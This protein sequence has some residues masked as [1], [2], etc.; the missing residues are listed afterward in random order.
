MLVKFDQDKIT[1]KV[2]NELGI[3]LSEKLE[4]N[5]RKFHKLMKWGYV[6]YPKTCVD[7]K[8]PKKCNLQVVLHGCYQ[9]AK[10][11]ADHWVPY[12]QENELVL[13]LP[14]AN[15]CWDYGQDEKNSAERAFPNTN[16]I[17]QTGFQ[18]NFFMKI[19]E[20]VTKP[21]ETEYEYFYQV[22]DD[23]DADINAEFKFGY[24]EFFP[25][26]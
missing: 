25:T 5:E 20:Q 14:Q 4:M 18:N 15:K 7:T 21:L 9:N 10:E 17:T 3:T 22:D 8:N 13:I 12:A 19:I 6:Y 16:F 11:M 1:A 26:V 23:G 24:D 2:V